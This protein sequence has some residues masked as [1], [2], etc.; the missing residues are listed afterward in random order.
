MIVH[1]DGN[2]ELLTSWHDV[3]QIITYLWCGQSLKL[4]GKK[5]IGYL[6]ILQDQSALEVIAEPSS[7]ILLESGQRRCFVTIHSLKGVDM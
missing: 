7:I 4:K 5:G 1:D 3:I 2:V 6:I